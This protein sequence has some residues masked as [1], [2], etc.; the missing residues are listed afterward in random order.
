MAQTFNDFVAECASYPYSKENYE[1]MKEC[2]ELVLIE[3]YVENQ[4]YYAENVLEMDG[5][6]SFTEG[7]FIE[8]ASS[9]RL[10][11][12][13]ESF[14]EKISKVAS[15]I[16]NGFKRVIAG[17][18]NFFKKIGAK[19]SD[20]SKKSSEYY[21]KLK[22]ANLSKEQ[23]EEIGKGLASLCRSSGLVIYKAQ[24]FSVELGVTGAV[25]AT[26]LKYYQVA[27]STTTVKLGLEDSDNC[28]DAGALAK[29]MHKFV[30]GK[31]NY[32]FESVSKIIDSERA[33]GKKTGVVVYANDKAINKV[34]ASLEE[35]Q[36]LAEYIEKAQTD[37]AKE[38]GAKAA[39]LSKMREAWAKINTTVAATIKQYNG[40]VKYR[41]R[42][43][44]E[45]DKVLGG[46]TKDANK[47]ANKGDEQK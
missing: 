22:A 18:I 10:E 44:Y 45:F 21:K 47:D 17:F 14:G 1:L 31:K 19:Y 34:V 6:I 11:A 24:P 28:V 37:K 29:V 46:A 40:Y 27:L 43:F 38:D 15:T 9:E 12:I 36:K 2:S 32:D 39:D 25:A 41:W 20:S 7:Y 30:K 5:E 42:A 3:Q 8:S 4:A 35:S 33:E 13:T 23:Y 16:A 26:Y